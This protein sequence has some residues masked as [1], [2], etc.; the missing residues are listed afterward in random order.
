MAKVASV[1]ALDLSQI[2]TIVGNHF[3]C[4]NS[5]WELIGRRRFKPTR[6]LS[7]PSRRENLGTRLGLRLL[8]GCQ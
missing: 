5:H 2:A 1:S 8:A 6:V 7:Y 4:E 3:R